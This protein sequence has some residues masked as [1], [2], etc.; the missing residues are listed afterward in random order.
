[1]RAESVLRAGVHTRPLPGDEHATASITTELKQK[2]KKKK[3]Q[4]FRNRFGG[5]HRSC[6]AAAQFSSLYFW[7]MAST[8]G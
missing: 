1:M 7:S 8:D 2:K 3:T 5:F 6:L 4:L